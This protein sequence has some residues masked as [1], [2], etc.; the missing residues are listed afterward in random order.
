M[1]NVNQHFKMTIENKYVLYLIILYLATK[2]NC[3]YLNL[4]C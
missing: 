4:F 2:N 1:K 3:H